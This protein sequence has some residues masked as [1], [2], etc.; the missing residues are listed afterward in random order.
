MEALVKGSGALSRRVYIGRRK[1]GVGAKGWSVQ[2]GL[3]LGDLF[4]DSLSFE[5]RY[6]VI[7]SVLTPWLACR[8]LVQN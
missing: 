1:K 4:Y 6:K 2:F 5:H 3:S 7:L 8:V